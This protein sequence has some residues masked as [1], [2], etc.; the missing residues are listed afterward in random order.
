MSMLEQQFS[1]SYTLVICPGI[2]S[3]QLTHSFIEGI[4]KNLN[5]PTYMVLPTQIYPPYSAI[6]INGW[7]KQF[8]GQPSQAPPLSF[9]AFSAGVVGAIGVAWLWQ[10]QGGKIR[11]LIAFDGWGMPLVGNFPIYRVSHDY[12]THWTSAPL[13]SGK[14]GFYADPGVEHLELWRSPETCQGW[15]VIG[16]GLKFRHSLSDYLQNLT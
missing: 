10:L 5:L 13:G 4:K 8:Y 7:L 16:R 15:Q 9:F 14:Q 11:N 12:F 3:S 2:H 1:S 6:A